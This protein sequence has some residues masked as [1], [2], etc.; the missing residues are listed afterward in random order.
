M[1]TR[2]FPC[3]TPNCPGERIFHQGSRSWTHTPTLYDHDTG[4][5]PSCNASCTPEEGIA[6]ATELLRL[7][8]LSG[9]ASLEKNSKHET[10]ISQKK[11]GNIDRQFQ[12]QAAA[13][14]DLLELA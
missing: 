13:D 9:Q 5:C 4:Y 2:N 3:S 6:V 8:A 1:D 12:R 11:R 14:T 7:E 10:L